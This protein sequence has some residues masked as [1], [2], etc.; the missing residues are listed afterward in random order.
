MSL[1]L[2][3]EPSI[4]TA[5]ARSFVRQ[6]LL[7][8]EAA[9]R[10]QQEAQTEQR[11][12]I[13]YLAIHRILPER[14]I[15]ATVSAEFGIPLF[16]LSSLDITAIPHDV[17]NSNLVQMHRALPIMHRGGHLLIAVSNPANDGLDEIKF[18]T[19]AII[20]PVVVEYNLLTESIEK[21]LSGSQ[22]GM[23]RLAMDSNLEDIHLE[24]LEDEQDSPTPAEETQDDTPVVRFVNKM[25]LDAV[26][27]GVSDIHLEPHEKFCRIRFRI[28]GLLHEVTRPP[29][30]LATR[31]A[32][33]LKVMSQMDISERR[34]PQDG[35][36]RMRF[37]NNRV[38]DFRISTLPTLH[39]EKV[40]LRILNSA[41]AQ[42]TI[43]ELG[44]ESRQQSLYL[45]AL[46]R[47][48]GMLL[49]TGPTGSG[50][51]VSLYAGLR[52]LN[53]ENVNIST[54][55][56]PVEINL[57]GV[58]QVNINLKA[59]LDFATTLRA[60]LRQDPDI[61]MVGE[62]RD[63][64]TAEIAIKAAETGH[65]VLATLHAGSA[66]QTLNR[67]SSLG[68]PAFHIANAVS[69]I[70]AQRLARR[71]C[72]HCKTPVNPDKYKLLSLPRIP[73]AQFFE[74]VGCE[75]CNGGYKGR[76]GIFEVMHITERI[77]RLV[78]DNSDVTQVIRQAQAEGFQ[79]LAT[80]AMQ[81]AALGLT[82]LP[83]AQRIT[84]M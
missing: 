48:Q 5:M 79:D 41:N 36:I 28:D 4:L 62:I 15:A 81:S 67:L 77:S 10:I 53:T 37:S 40:V 55:E 7:Q 65:L 60:L 68:I 83:E 46:R 50:K 13:E 84:L 51:T 34:R 33:R 23:E 11:Q 58:N 43:E 64:Q 56:D 2:S 80:S 39:G 59:G 24:M 32:S 21:Y 71:L 16:D 42:I 54:V 47:S 18:Q 82:S 61:I 8:P 49:I 57:E 73:D 52:L 30:S 78:L 45:E 44:L 17:V 31:I 38:F 72:E 26:N 6:G 75:N 27:D 3:N 69:L 14:D 66:A 12:L 25:L 74:A 1:S 29:T 70:I 35:R 20:E 76:L 9:L 63:S 19:G 22:S